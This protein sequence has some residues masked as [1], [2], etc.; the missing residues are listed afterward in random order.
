MLA[1]NVSTKLMFLFTFNNVRRTSQNGSYCC[2]PLARFIFKHLGCQVLLFTMAF[3]IMVFFAWN[4]QGRYSQKLSLIYLPSLHHAFL[5]HWPA[6]RS[7][8]LTALTLLLLL[9]PV[10]GLLNA[11]VSFLSFLYPVSLALYWCLIHA[12]SFSSKT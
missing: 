10:E 6:A 11:C 5:L 9:P 12:Y 4:A 8:Q 2:S 1:L 3:K 7:N